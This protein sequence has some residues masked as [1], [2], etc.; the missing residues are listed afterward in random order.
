MKLDD[1]NVGIRL[2]HT[3]RNDDSLETRPCSIL[4]NLVIVTLIPQQGCSWKEL[5]MTTT[6]I[7][8]QYYWLQCTCWVQDDQASNIG[9]GQSILCCAGWL[10][11]PNTCVWCPLSTESE[12]QQSLRWEYHSI[13]H[14][15]WGQ[16]FCPQGYTLCHSHRH[17]W[18]WRW[19]SAAATPCHFPGRY[20]LKKSMHCV[21]LCFWTCDCIFAISALRPSESTRYA[22][23][24]LGLQQFEVLPL[25]DALAYFT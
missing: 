23:D 4:L 14:I 7:D 18:C 3:D 11:Q 6:K 25:L 19:S 16:R 8:P 17:V 24:I 10:Q 21:Q 22:S 9:T 2:S 1:R 20:N 13:L 12:V 5:S 15:G